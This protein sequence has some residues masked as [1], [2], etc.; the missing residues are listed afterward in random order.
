M[1]I[2]SMKVSGENNLDFRYSKLLNTFNYLCA[3]MTSE[4]D[5][6]KRFFFDRKFFTIG[7]RRTLLKFSDLVDKK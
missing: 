7:F 4:D 2:K 1:G 6:R 5:Q 3:C